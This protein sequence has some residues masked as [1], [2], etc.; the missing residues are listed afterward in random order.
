MS[1]KV[2]V[3][4]V[5]SD[6]RIDVTDSSVLRGDGCFEVMRA[7]QGRVFA[8]TD[9]LDRLEKSARMLGIAL[10]AR[11]DLL[12]WIEGAAA[13]QPDGAVRVVVT[14]GSA[15]P[16]E[17]QHPLVVVFAHLWSEGPD[18]VAL[19]PVRAPWHGAG[20][21]WEL[22]GAKVL[23]YA[24][25]LSA[26]RS[27]RADGFDDAVLIS[28]EGVVLEGP[29]FSLAWVCDGVIETPAL[30]LG[31]LDSI[32]RRHV[33]DLAA[34]EGLVTVEGSWNLSRLETADEV[35]ALSTIRQVQPVSKV[36]NLA[37]DPG[38]VTRRLSRAYA[39]LVGSAL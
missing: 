14:R 37:F 31:I 9:H 19:G 18:A 22:S 30:S 16:G 6:G 29:T 8:A 1:R 32:T 17:E 33:L 3:N 2:W 24:P 23:S 39:Q 11:E 21:E 4:G 15:I 34:E 36:G 12:S 27:A 38:P 25:N 28:T 7:Y 10:P 20:E 13:D 35:M 26:T 5:L